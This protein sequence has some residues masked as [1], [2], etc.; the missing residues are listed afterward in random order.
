MPVQFAPQ[1]GVGFGVA[2]ELA[3]HGGALHDRGGA[4]AV[5]SGRVVHGPAGEV[6]DLVEEVRLSFSA[7]RRRAPRRA[8]VSARG[9]GR[10]GAACRAGCR[11]RCAASGRRLRGGQGG[12]LGGSGSVRPRRPGPRRSGTARRGGPARRPATPARRVSAAAPR[13]YSCRRQGSVLLVDGGPDCSGCA[14]V[15]RCP[16]PPLRAQDQVAAHRPAQRRRRRRR[17]RVSCGEGADRS[18]RSRGRRAR[19][20]LPRRRARPGRVRGDLVEQQ[21]F[22]ARRCTTTA[23]AGA[24]PPSV[25][26]LVTT[27]DT[28]APPSTG[29]V[30]RAGPGRC[31]GRGTAP[32]REAGRAGQPGGRWA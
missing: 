29:V 9:A 4:Q 24:R 2:A 6:D 16:A 3:F 17:R 5:L 31:P 27:R 8:A 13:R 22:Q 32:G 25:T 11:A 1:Q 23:P 12:L 21:H 15:R 20:R 18:R 30:A 14:V 28:R 10:G 26:R 7:P 19:R